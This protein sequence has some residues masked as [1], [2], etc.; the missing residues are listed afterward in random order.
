L[1]PERVAYVPCGTGRIGLLD[2]AD[3]NRQGTIERGA[4]IGRRRVTAIARL[5]GGGQRKAAS[6]I[7]GIDPSLPHSPEA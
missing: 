2:Y 6:A 1:L 5:S 4:Q 3:A 7:C